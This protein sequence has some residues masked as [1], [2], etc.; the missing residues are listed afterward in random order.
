MGEVGVWVTGRSGFWFEFRAIV[1]DC[2]EIGVATSCISFSWP[3]E[4]KRLRPISTPQWEHH[5]WHSRLP[6]RKTGFV[7]QKRQTCLRSC[8]PTTKKLPDLDQLQSRRRAQ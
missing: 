6:Q 7:E 3:A 4:W 5:E 2:Q 8:L 1:N